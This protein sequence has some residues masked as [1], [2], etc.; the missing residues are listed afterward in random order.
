MTLYE[1]L[2]MIDVGRLCKKNNY[3]DKMTNEDYN[4]MLNR[5][6][7]KNFYSDGGFVKRNFTALDI[8]RLA[9]EIKAGT[10]TDLT[11]QNIAGEIFRVCVRRWCSD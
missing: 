2:N 11:A 3:C 6:Y 8:L 7:S 10:D 9:A 4:E 5:T 1:R